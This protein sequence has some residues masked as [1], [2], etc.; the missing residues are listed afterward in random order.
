M[1]KLDQALSLIGNPQTRTDQLIEPVQCPGP[2]VRLKQLPHEF[3]LPLVQ[4]RW[5]ARNRSP[6]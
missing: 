6:A 2:R 1:Q 5:T 4:S 3:A